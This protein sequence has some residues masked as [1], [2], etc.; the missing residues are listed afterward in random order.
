MMGISISTLTSIIHDQQRIELQTK[1]SG[2]LVS[3]KMRVQEIKFPK[4]ERTLLSFFNQ[5]FVSSIPVS[6]QQLVQFII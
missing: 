5:C 1:V 6:G 3:K 2:S 4:R